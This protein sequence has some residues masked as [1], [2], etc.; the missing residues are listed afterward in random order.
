LIHLI[1]PTVAP[2]VQH[3]TKL[4]LLLAV[5]IYA[6]RFVLPSFPLVSLLV[7]TVVPITTAAGIKPIVLLLV[8][9]TAASV[10]F[11][12]YQSAYYLALYFGTKEQAFSHRQARP[13]AWAYGLIYLMA[14]AAG[15]PLWRFL[16]LLPGGTG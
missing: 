13:M 16:G 14:I 15:I 10:W 11:M 7:L 5:S 12:P 8:I 3:P 6:A 2:L 4:L 1:E 9:S